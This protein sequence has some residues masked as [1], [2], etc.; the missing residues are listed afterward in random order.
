MIIF[1]QSFNLAQGFHITSITGQW[2]TTEG[3]PVKV[4]LQGYKTSQCSGTNV[5][6]TDDEKVMA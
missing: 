6:P 1:L 4:T 3:E 2:Y 5:P